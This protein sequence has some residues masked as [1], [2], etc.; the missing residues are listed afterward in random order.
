MIAIVVSLWLCLKN[1]GQR[2]ERYLPQW[3]AGVTF[4]EHEQD[5]EQK[6]DS[7]PQS[8]PESRQ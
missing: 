5:Q 6:I 2:V 3:E 1:S 4:L 8:S 7:D